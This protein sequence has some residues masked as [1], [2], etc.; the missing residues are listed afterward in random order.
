MRQFLITI[1]AFFL[2]TSCVHYSTLYAENNPDN[3]VAIQSYYSPCCGWCGQR[4]ISDNLKGEQYSLL[5]NCKIESKYS[6][7]CTALEIGTQKHIDVYKKKFVT[8]QSIYRPVYDTIE[9]KQ[10][11][12]NLER[13]A[14]FDTLMLTRQIIP[15]TNLDSALI[16]WALEFKGDTTC[17]NDHLRLIR[18]YIFVRTEEVKMKK[19]KDFKT[20][21]K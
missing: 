16:N 1:A 2:F 19:E 5:I 8:Q 21:K 14:Y 10:N 18:G 7:Y 3:K 6:R 17:S 20:P 11:Y 9:L 15:L 4:I 13:E 12:P